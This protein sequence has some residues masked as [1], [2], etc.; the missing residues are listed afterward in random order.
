M[1][2]R[3]GARGG[4]GGEFALSQFWKPEVRGQGVGRVGS[5]WK[6]GGVICSGPLPW[7]LV[8]AR[9]LRGSSLQ[10]LPLSPQGLPL[11]IPLKMGVNLITSAS[12]LFPR[13][14]PVY[15]SQ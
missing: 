14:A 6:L 8:I 15:T 2:Q 11:R 3:G 5:F 4:W 12:S 1:P 9:V 10:S 13:K 7:L